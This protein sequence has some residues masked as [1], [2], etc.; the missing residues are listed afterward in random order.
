MIESRAEYLIL[1]LLIEIEG[2]ITVLLQPVSTR[3]VASCTLTRTGIVTRPSAPT[4][5]GPQLA[6]AMDRRSFPPRLGP[7]PAGPPAI[8]HTPADG[9]PSC[10]TSRIG[11][12]APFH[13]LRL[14]CSSSS[15]WSGRPAASS[16]SSSTSCSSLFRR[17]LLRPSRPRR[18]TR[19][20]YRPPSPAPVQEAGAR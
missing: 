3:A 9:A 1:C 19:Q 2:P 10:S 14:G 4:H 11:R 16:S 7:S 8:L 6:L 18:H 12:P 5:V 13:P 20:S 15:G 17:P